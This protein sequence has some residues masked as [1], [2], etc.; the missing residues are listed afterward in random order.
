M[1][2]WSAQSSDTSLDKLASATYGLSMSFAEIKARVAGLSPEERLE[3][4]ALIAHLSHTD[5]P[6]YQADLDRR[7]AEMDSGRKFGQADLARVH[8]ELAAHEE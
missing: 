5:D 6:Q 2:A 8:S 4:A 3:L 7:L 1:W